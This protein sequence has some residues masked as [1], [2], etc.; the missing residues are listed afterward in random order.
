MRTP[1]YL[2]RSAWSSSKFLPFV[3]ILIC[4]REAREIVTLTQGQFRNNTGPNTVYMLDHTCHPV[5]H[6]D[7]VTSMYSKWNIRISDDSGVV[8]KR[9]W[10][11]RVHGGDGAAD[12]E[13]AVHAVHDPQVQDVVDE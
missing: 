3:K 4:Y 9:I 13:G 6:R 1:T 12:V 7:R 2:P 10:R 5:L 8:P 11:D